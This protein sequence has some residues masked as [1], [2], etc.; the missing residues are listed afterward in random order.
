MPTRVCHTQ[1]VTPQQS[2]EDE[3]EDEPTITSLVDR[4]L[5]HDIHMETI[6]ARGCLSLRRSARWMRDRYG[7]DCGEDA[8]VSAIRRY[9]PSKQLARDDELLAGVDIT[10]QTGLCVAAVQALPEILR[11]IP[12]A[13]ATTGEG[14]FWAHL[15]SLKEDR[16]VFEVQHE[17]AVME[18]LHEHDDD[19]LLEAQRG[20]ARVTFA[21]PETDVD[22]SIGVALV[23]S[24]LARDGIELLGQTLAGTELT[25][26]VHE[27]QF[28][29]TV[30]VVGRLKENAS[31]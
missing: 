30:S 22:P 2:T 21:F 6:L 23:L 14:R 13:E 24:S 26:F 11:Q 10:A 5:S 18:A 3:E 8:V 27:S 4:H 28:T 31:G 12:E 25:V 17:D 16:L 29:A 9:E 1:A 19:A 20:V 15:P 7:W